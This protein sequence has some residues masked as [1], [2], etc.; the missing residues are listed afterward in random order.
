MSKKEKWQEMMDFIVVNNEKYS[1]EQFAERFSL[2]CDEIP[3]GMEIT[4]IG[5]NKIITS[6]VLAYC[7]AKGIQVA[8]YDGPMPYRQYEIPV[9]SEKL[10]HKSSTIVTTDYNFVNQEFTVEF[11]GNNTYIYSKVPLNIYNKFKQSESKGSFL[12]KE[13]KGTFDFIKIEEDIDKETREKYPANVEGSKE[14]NDA[15]T[16]EK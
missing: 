2:A 8:E 13:I 3:L 10:E 9:G 5:C 11:K 6:R 14:F 16:N 15:N 4:H 1:D 7:E 12:S